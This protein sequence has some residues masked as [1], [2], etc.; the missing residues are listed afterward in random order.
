MPRAAESAATYE[1]LRMGLL[2]QD[3]AARGLLRV[4]LPPPLQVALEEAFIFLR[5]RLGVPPAVSELM[6]ERPRLR[7]LRVG[8][9]QVCRVYNAVLGSLSAEDRRLCRD[10]IRFLDRRVLPGVNKLGWASPRHQTDFYQ[11][12]ALRCCKDVA[13][14]AAELRAASA[15]VA[16]T[17]A[18]CKEALLV[19]VERKRLHDLPGWEARQAAHQAA[20]R[21]RIAA[22]CSAL[23]A[24]LV[25]L[26]RRFAADGEDVQ[27]EWL[28]FLRRADA[29]LL[30]ALT[31]CVRRSLHEVAGALQG[32]QRGA[33]ASPVFVLTVVLDTNMRVELR[34]TLQQLYAAVLATCNGAVAALEGL[35]RL[36]PEVLAGCAA[37][38][39]LPASL[40]AAET[41]PSFADAVRG[42]EEAVT[43]QMQAVTTGISGIVEKVQ[44]LLSFHEGKYMT[45]LWQTECAAY[46]R[47]YERANK[48]ASSFMADIQKYLDLREEVLCEDSASS[49]RWLRLDASM[50]KQQLVTLCDNWVAAFQGLLASLA[51]RQLSGLTDELTNYIGQ[52]KGRAPQPPPCQAAAGEGEEGLQDRGKAS[53]TDGSDEAAQGAAGKLNALAP[54]QAQRTQQ[55]TVEELE[56]LHGRLQAHREELEERVVECQQ[57]YE[58]LV[59]LQVGIPDE[60]L[61][62]VDAL[63]GLWAAFTSA[64]DAVPA[65][66]RELWDA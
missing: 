28:A 3:A 35:P 32:E 50:L 26:H 54:A 38:G 25:C 7:G 53:D 64:L 29:Q 62:G 27:Q 39:P 5:Q 41:P 9:A 23:R 46:M 44:Q 30:E 6:Q 18:L 42:S 31:A 55:Q 24:R 22:A 45:A 11:R 52:L 61:M 60:E 17:C 15:A 8:A 56:A 49:V 33:E 16:S 36:L 10:R 66:L 63:P 65:R 2:W 59:Q 40:R 4:A 58:A 21:A 12:D 43:K 37:D 19:R 57:K 20:T 1:A 47:R 34:P 13:A 51:S 14:A 48:P